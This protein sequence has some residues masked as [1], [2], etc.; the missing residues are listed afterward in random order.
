M[1]FRR[2]LVLALIISTAIGIYAVTHHTSAPTDSTSAY[3]LIT[4]T[5]LETSVPTL[6][7][8]TTIP[9]MTRVSSIRAVVFTP[10][11]TVTASASSYSVAS[12]SDVIDLKKLRSKE[13]AIEVHKV[14]FGENYWT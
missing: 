5:V 8:T 1:S 2:F 3:I 12:P 9:T 14:D 13:V 7:T 11:P 10:L 4:P 6:V